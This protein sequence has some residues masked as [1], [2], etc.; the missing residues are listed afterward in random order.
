[1]DPANTGAR[2]L[3]GIDPNNVSAFNVYWTSSPSTIE[4]DS[5][6]RFRDE[7]VGA[8]ITRKWT[9][10]GG[11]PATSTQANPVVRYPQ[12]GTYNVSLEITFN[13]KKYTKARTDYVYVKSK[14]AWVLQ[15]TRF[16]KPERGIQGI[17]IIDSLHV[18]AWA[19]D[20]MDASNQIKE[21]TVTENGGRTWKTDSIVS[22]ALIGY[23]IGN[24]YPINKDTIYATVF[25]PNG[26]GKVLCS[27]NSGDS[28]VIQAGAA[29]NS[30][31]SFPN[32]VYFF[33]KNTGI[34]CGDPTDGNF[35][36][37]ITSNGGNDWTIVPKANIPTN[38][39]GET[40]T[41]NMYDA[42][43]DTIWFGTSEG[44]VYRSINR[45]LNWTVT[46]TGLTGQTTVKFRNSKVGFAIARGTNYAVKKTLDGGETWQDYTLPPYFLKGDLVY[47][48]GTKA[49]WLNVS[50]GYPSGSSFTT[51]DGASFSP[52]DVGIQYTTVAF[53]DEYTGWAGSFNIDST[54]GGI[55]KWDKMNPLLTDIRE[56][57]GDSTPKGF[58]EL[59]PNPIENLAT[60]KINGDMKRGTAYVINLQG[61]C[62]RTFNVAESLGSSSQ[63]F[64]FS[65]LLAGV[66]IL[67]VVS[68]EHTE[69]IRFLKF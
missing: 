46:L 55:Y 21:Y 17:G 59:F 4:M 14:S 31:E 20:G 57:P 27:R 50:S 3:R 29:Y 30:P 53:F 58:I 65:G 10:E 23:G 11:E 34:V 40:G 62:V 68:T 39:T 47:V 32:F 37:Y 44:R 36:I 7:T 52:I 64:D 13:G 8:G 45:G 61:K 2:K 25:G 66:Y 69:N 48:P 26:G 16:S 67:Q 42:E 38:K 5:T 18:W 49:T 33:D 51:N 60:L 41:T 28:W 35:E 63:S 15:H 54:L 1:L 9:F 19:Y 56:F 6:V 43:G 22:D 24:I 12:P